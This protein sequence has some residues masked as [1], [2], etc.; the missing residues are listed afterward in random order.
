MSMNSSIQCQVSFMLGNE[1]FGLPANSI[2]SIMPVPEICQLPHTADYLLGVIKVK[3]TIIPIID[4][5][6]KLTGA[7]TRMTADC[8]IIIMDIDYSQ[9]GLLVERFGGSIDQ[10]ST[11][12][13]PLG[14]AESEVPGNYLLGITRSGNSMIKILNT[15]ALLG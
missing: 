12:M 10:E 11:E 9:V 4:L 7:S 13:E 3:G 5:K 8:R 15:K 6:M 14:E 2:S 1:E